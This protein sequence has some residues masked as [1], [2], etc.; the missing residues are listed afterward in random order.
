MSGRLSY[1]A[2]ML[3]ALGV[4]L[5]VR[6]WVPKPDALTVLPWRKRAALSVAAFVGGMFGAKLP[7]ALGS[8]ADFFSGDAWLGDGKTIVTGLIGAYLAVEGTKL[9]L[10]IPFKTGDT[11]ALPLALAL[12][13][14]R[15]GC[16]F[17]GCCYGVPTDLSWG[18]TFDVGG[19]PTKCHPTQIYECFFH[20]WMAAILLLL[21]RLDLLRGHHLQ[22]YLIAYGIYRFLTEFIRPEPV[23]RLQLTFYQWAAVVLAGGLALQWLV[24][25]RKPSRGMR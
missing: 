19:V 11:F 4:C 13:V 7:F 25:S 6:A 24:E 18:V 22:F 15:W 3:L 2:F 9:A 17:N 8:A 5:S 1:A 10:A 23:W 21:L 16:F 14:G 12:A 20:L